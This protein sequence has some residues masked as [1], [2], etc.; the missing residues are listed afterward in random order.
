M[1]TAPTTTTTTT[2]TTPPPLLGFRKPDG[3][4]VTSEVFPEF[5]PASPWN[6]MEL[7]VP[8]EPIRQDLIEVDACL[9]SSVT[10]GWQLANMLAWYEDRFHP[11]LHSHHHHEDELAFP[12]LAKKIEV[13]KEYASDHLKVTELMDRLSSLAKELFAAGG[14]DAPATTVVSVLDRTRTAWHELRELVLP[15]LAAEERLYVKDGPIVAKFTSAEMDE[16]TK[17]IIKSQ[18][19]ALMRV[20]LPW[21]VEAMQ[22]WGGQKVVDDFLVKI[23]PPVKWVLRTFW[24]P[25]YLAYHRGALDTLG[26][27]AVKRIVREPKSGG[28]VVA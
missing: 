6:E 14:A 3:R 4:V 15:H 27:G 1:A 24:M 22:R 5:S 7:L 26:K 16:L 18:G 2:T 19:P 17:K 23:P 11:F 25:A 10:E 13:P 9:Q 8:H 12:F 21:I 28:C 20:G